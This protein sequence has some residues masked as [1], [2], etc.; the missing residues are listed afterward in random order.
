MECNF[1]NSLVFGGMPQKPT[2]ETQGKLKYSVGLFTSS[3]SVSIST[4][5]VSSSDEVSD[6]GNLERSTKVRVPMPSLHQ[7]FE[8]TF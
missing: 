5:G 1:L 4:L 6:W 7:A 3:S 2:G 8:L